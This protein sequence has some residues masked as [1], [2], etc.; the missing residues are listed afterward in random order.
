MAEKTADD[1]GEPT[2]DRLQDGDPSA[3]PALERTPA[4]TPARSQPLSAEEAH[5]DGIARLEAFRAETSDIGYD[6]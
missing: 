5:A 2:I 4:L 1:R 3:L 6:E